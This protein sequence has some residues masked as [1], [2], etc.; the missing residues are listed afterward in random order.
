MPRNPRLHVPGGHYHVILR[1]NGR[2][3]IF[4]DADDRSRWESW[5]AKG[6]SRYGHRLHAYCW[7][8]NHVHMAIQCGDNRLAELMRYLAGGYARSTNKRL[9]RSGHLFERRHRA[10]LVD[11]DGYLLQLV[12]YIHRNPLRAGLVT[13]LSEYPWSSHHA[14]QAGHGPSWL[15]QEWVLDLFGGIPAK[16][17]RQYVDFVATASDPVTTQGFTTGRADDF[18]SSPRCAPAISGADRDLAGLTREVCE[19][20]G[21]NLAA[22][23]S[24]SRERRLA[25]I[26][27]EIGMLA[28]D[29]GIATNAEVARFFRRSQAGLSRAVWPLRRQL[30]R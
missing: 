26:R 22:L 6:L 15:T 14:Y 4:F 30:K 17:R 29:G 23:R 3:A 21:I 13:A 7:M 25:R 9:K 12:R 19:K 5:L 1:G 28:I 16:A 10:I 24:P 20:Y 8:T 18:A 27:A 11:G 2:Q